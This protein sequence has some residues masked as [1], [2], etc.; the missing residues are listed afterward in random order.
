[1]GAAGSSRPTAGRARRV[2][3]APHEA[4][5]RDVFAV[6]ALM[7]WQ[8]G[9]HAW[10]GGCLLAVGSP[11]ESPG[12]TMQTENA[13]EWVGKARESIDEIRVR[14]EGWDVRVRQFA[15]ERPL[16]AVLCAAA[17]GYALARLVT[18]R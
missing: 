6:W 8:H 11:S 3:A 1:M 15:R 4:G 17:G 13:V 18:W 7:P 10:H 12:E 16:A 2:V 9:R 5:W 14:A